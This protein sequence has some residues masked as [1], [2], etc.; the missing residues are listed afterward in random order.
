MLYL[1]AQLKFFSDLIW[2]EFTSR[3]G[4]H[5]C[6]YI[7]DEWEIILEMY[8]YKSLHCGVLI[9]HGNVQAVVRGWLQD[10]VCGGQIR[11]VFEICPW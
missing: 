7:Q 2:S 11:I 9:Q 1:F 5:L 3:H 4:I 6:V 8:V 10:D